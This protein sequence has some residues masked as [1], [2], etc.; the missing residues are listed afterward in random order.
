MILMNTITLTKIDVFN[1]K[2]LDAEEIQEIYK[3]ERKPVLYTDILDIC[4]FK[5]AIHQELNVIYIKYPT[6]K[7]RCEVYNARSI[8][9][10]DG[11]L[12]TDNHVAKCN[13]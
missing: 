6:I 8:S 11:K 1:T 7:N 5:I 9:H 4:K 12:L 2:I 13:N 10:N 3:H